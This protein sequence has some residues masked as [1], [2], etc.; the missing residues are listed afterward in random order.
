M[1]VH[2]QEELKGRRGRG[3]TGFLV[4]PTVGNSLGV[5]REIR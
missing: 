2:T 1:F 4:W 3:L 5:A